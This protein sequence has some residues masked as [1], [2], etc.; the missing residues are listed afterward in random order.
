MDQSELKRYRA[1]FEKEIR[2]NIL[3]FWIKFGVDRA[4]GGFHGEVDLSGTPIK[5]ANKACVLITRIL[6][7]FSA[8]ARVFDD[9]DYRDLAKRAFDVVDHSFADSKYG[10]Y[11]MQLSYDC[12]PL[13]D[14]KHTYAQAFALYSLCEYY[15]LA[16]SEDLLNKI[17]Q[18]FNLL[19]EKTKDSAHPGY[20]EAFTRRWEP[21][22]ENRM[23]D[24]NEPKSMNTHLHLLEAYAA[25]YRVW[26]DER[27]KQR[28]QELI[29]IFLDFIIDDN[30]HF[31]L[32]FE[33]DFSESSQSKGIVSFGHDIE[34]Q[35][36]LCEAAEILGDPQL[37]KRVTDVAVEMVDAVE[38][39]GVDKDG[40]LFL[41]SN[42][43]GSHVRTNKHWWLQAENLVGFMNAYQLTGAPKYWEVVKLSWRFIDK[44]V[45]DHARG[46]WFAKVNRS[47]VPFLVEPPDDLSPYYR[48]DRKIDAWKCPYHNGRACLELM[49]RIDDMIVRTKVAGS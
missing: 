29:E 25:V 32:F 11:Y 36:L 39:E 15:R 1:I 9:P 34:G 5:T 41:E 46:E 43:F 8:A 42:R 3:P 30:H 45:I 27:V 49:S 20:F 28:L 7:T 22:T 4:R 2:E 44:H 23:A 37:E 18:L 19:E 10:G 12:K 33:A 38:R 48:N 21:I 24:G 14:I 26:K 31:K 47:G 40:G 17:R 13:D 16:P 6:W 35:W